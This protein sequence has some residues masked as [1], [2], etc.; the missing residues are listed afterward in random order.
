MTVLTA[1]LAL[2]TDRQKNF[3]SRRQVVIPVNRFQKPEAATRWYLQ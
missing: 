2:E 3:L 1:V